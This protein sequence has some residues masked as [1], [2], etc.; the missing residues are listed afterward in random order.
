MCDIKYEFSFYTFFSGIIKK[1]EIYIIMQ[2]K[3]WLSKFTKYYTGD[4]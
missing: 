1:M 2:F 3:C 4:M